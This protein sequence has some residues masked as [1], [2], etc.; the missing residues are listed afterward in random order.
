[1][2]RSKDVSFLLNALHLDSC[3]MLSEALDYSVKPF[4]ECGLALW[5][6]AVLLSHKMVS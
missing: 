6:F 5:S 4:I 2:G 1:M 3:G